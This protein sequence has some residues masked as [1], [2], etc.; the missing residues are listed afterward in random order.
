MKHTEWKAETAKKIIDA[1]NELPEGERDAFICKHYK[2]MKISEIAE[3]LQRS[4]ED[5][6]HLLKQAEHRVNESFNRLN[7]GFYSTS[8]AFC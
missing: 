1:I 4:V 5:T 2:G 8:Y 7:H 6:S 3:K